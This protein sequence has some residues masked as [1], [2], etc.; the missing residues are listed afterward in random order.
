MGL[1][2]TGCTGLEGGEAATDGRLT[3][4]TLEPVSLGMPGLFGL[5][6]IRCGKE[7]MPELPRF[8]EGTIGGAEGGLPGRDGPNTGGPG[9]AAAGGLAAKG[10]GLPACVISSSSLP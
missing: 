1:A 7:L 3:G 8:T 9:L 5:L 6:G 10:D 4:A 2:A